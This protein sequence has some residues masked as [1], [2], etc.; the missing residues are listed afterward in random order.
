M[1]PYCL[2]SANDKKQ[3]LWRNKV[4]KIFITSSSLA[5]QV[6]QKEKYKVHLSVSMILAV[7]VLCV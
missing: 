1:K 5:L 3:I 4:D 6:D 2:G 7:R